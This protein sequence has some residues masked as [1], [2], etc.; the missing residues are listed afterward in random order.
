MKARVL[1]LTR[2]GNLGAIVLALTTA[3]TAHA[4][5][6]ADPLADL[7][8]ESKPADKAANV[9]AK[10]ASSRPRG[11]VPPSSSPS[12]EPASAP[13]PAAAKTPGIEKVDRTVTQTGKA[14]AESRATTA[15]P[16]ATA[17]PSKAVASPGVTT[18]RQLDEL[19]SQN[20]LLSE[21]VKA[22]ELR[23]KLAGQSGPGEAAG[24]PSPRRGPV[25]KAPLS[26]QAAQGA[27]VLSVY[28]VDGKLTA[29][30][31]LRNGATVKAQ[32]GAT[33][34]GLGSVKSISR[35]SVLVDTGTTTVGLNFVPVGSGQGA[36]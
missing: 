11:P 26:M 14:A 5:N 3:G 31:G 15:P 24:T 2:M 10:A 9:T 12:P 21:M 35:N 27:Q 6:V 19:R 29:V 28:G 30:V 16:T 36:R 1:D 4:G 22:A 18:L 17:A 32:E 23:A 13:A 20:A 34:P 25:D 33:I 8:N 7:P